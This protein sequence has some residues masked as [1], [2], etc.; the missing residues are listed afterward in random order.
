MHIGIDIDGVLSK[1]SP[2]QG[3]YAKG[4]LLLKLVNLLPGDI[5]K[6]WLLHRTAVR[7]DIQIAQEIT[8]NHRVT[9][10]TARPIQFH[11]VTKRWLTEYAQISFDNLYCIGLSH[12]VPE[13]KY[14]YAQEAG[15]DIFIDDTQEIT[16]YMED[17]GLPT[18]QFA[19]WQETA[20]ALKTY[21]NES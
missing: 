1:R 4:Q 20:E 2:I 21:A 19:S 18:I 3:S 14:T 15:V 13:R 10:I 8:Q 11:R 17:Q 5:G 16:K 12:H 9:V 7:D 6:Y